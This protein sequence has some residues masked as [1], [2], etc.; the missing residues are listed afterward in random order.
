MVRIDPLQDAIEALRVRFQ[1]LP[2][3]VVH[4]LRDENAEFVHAVEQVIAIAA[5]SHVPAPELGPDERQPEDVPSAG[6]YDGALDTQAP[7]KLHDVWNGQGDYNDPLTPSD[8][9]E[10]ELV[11]RRLREDSDKGVD[12]SWPAG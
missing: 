8:D 7:R 2:S 9:H 3:L 5:V 4:Q 10:H 1:G 12:S 11:L 6:L